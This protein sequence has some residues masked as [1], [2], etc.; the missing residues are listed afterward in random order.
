MECT[1]RSTDRYQIQ[2]LPLFF[3]S[4]LCAKGKCHSVF[5]IIVRNIYTPFVGQ[6]RVTNPQE[7]LRGRLGCLLTKRTVVQEVWMQCMVYLSLWPFSHV[8]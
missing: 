6:E 8:I 4:V 5:T 7:R 1:S 2:Q 3:K